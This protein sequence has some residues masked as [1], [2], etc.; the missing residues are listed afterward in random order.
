ML[1]LKRGKNLSC[2]KVSIAYRVQ[3][4]IMRI[5]LLLLTEVL[6]GHSFVEVDDGNKAT[7]CPEV[8]AGEIIAFP[9][10]RA[11]IKKWYSFGR[12]TC[13]IRHGTPR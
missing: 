3:L 11:E 2:V 4:L 8:F 7:P 6:S 13:H 12:Y 5:F 10:N 9:M 1:V